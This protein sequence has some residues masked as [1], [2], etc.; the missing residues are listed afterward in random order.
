MTDKAGSQD[1]KIIT[2]RPLVE[3]PTCGSAENHLILRDIRN[4]CRFLLEL[5]AL[6]LFAVMNVFHEDFKGFAHHRRCEQCGNKFLGRK[7]LRRER[8]LCTHCRYDLT[9]NE[10]GVCP[11]CGTEVQPS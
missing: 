2:V 10:S 5:A 4:W 8:G 9:G 3:C 11:E 6:P 7:D 1:R